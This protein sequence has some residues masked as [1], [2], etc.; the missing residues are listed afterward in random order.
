MLGS[1]VSGAGG[2]VAGSGWSATYDG[3]NALMAVPAAGEPARSVE[4]LRSKSL[5]LMNRVHYD[6][7]DDR[8]WLAELAQDGGEATLWSAQP[9]GSQLV[10]LH[11][12]RSFGGDFAVSPDGLSILYLGT[13]QSPATATLR[14]S[15]QEIRLSLGLVNA[16]SPVFSPDGK[17]V[18]L[19]GSDTADGATSLWIYDLEAQTCTRIESTK[20]LYPTFPAFSPD[21]QRI[22]FRNWRLGDVWTVAL[23]SGKLTRYALSVADAPIAW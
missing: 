16:C 21:G 10:A 6:A 11:L 7:N 1:V 2:K 8:V 18:C 17:K 13:Q 15:T 19:V 5:P 14:T 20:G 12:T 4:L 22:A 9:H 3:E 23:D